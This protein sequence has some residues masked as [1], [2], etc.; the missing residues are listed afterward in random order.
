MRC[1]LMDEQRGDLWHKAT[2]QAAQRAHA[3]QQEAVERQHAHALIFT[4]AFRQHRHR[5]DPIKRGKDTV[6]EGGDQ[7]RRHR[8][9]E[10][11]RHQRERSNQATDE[12]HRPAPQAV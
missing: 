7:Q 2:D 9:A 10:G 3:Q 4:D 8:G 11:Y 5:R 1:W 6:E 12:H